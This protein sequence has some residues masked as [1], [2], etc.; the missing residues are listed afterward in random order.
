[1]IQTNKKFIGQDFINLEHYD[2][3]ISFFSPVQ[4]VSINENGPINICFEDTYIDRKQTLNMQNKRSI[5]Y[6]MLKIILRYIIII[7]QWISNNI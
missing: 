1:M 5:L 3:V 4:T 6:H 7:L 2:G